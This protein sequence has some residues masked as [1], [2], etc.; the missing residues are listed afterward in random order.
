MAGSTTVT[1]NK[2][3]R[4]KTPARSQ[5]RYGWRKR[6]AQALAFAIE[7]QRRLAELVKGEEL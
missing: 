7:G 2:G 5:V 4:R 6:Q 3:R 1:G